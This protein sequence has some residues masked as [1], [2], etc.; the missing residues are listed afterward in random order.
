MKHRWPASQPRF[1][2]KA[3]RN[4]VLYRLPQLEETSLWAASLFELKIILHIIY[5]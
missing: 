5:F 4:E 1:E 2:L 3:V